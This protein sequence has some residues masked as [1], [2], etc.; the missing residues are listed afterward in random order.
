[1]QSGTAVRFFLLL[2]SFLVLSLNVYAEDTLTIISPTYFGEE[3]N[4]YEDIHYLKNEHLSV[5]LCTDGEIKDLSAKIVCNSN[6]TYMNLTTS[7]YKGANVCHFS[8]ANLNETPCADFTLDINYKTSNDKEKNIKRT[9]KRQA[10]SK[11]LNYI[12]GTNIGTLDEVE[13]SYFLIVSRD[14]GD[15][16]TKKSEEVYELLK[17]KRSNTDKCWPAGS[18]SQLKTS[19]IIRNLEWASYSEDTR[20]IEDGRIYLEKE[21]SDRTAFEIEGEIR[22]IHDASEGDINCTLT[23]NG[24]TT[25]TNYSID[26]AAETITMEF[27]DSF[28]FSCDG[29]M[30]K[31]TLTMFN[32]AGDL[33]HKTVYTS[34]SSIS[35]TNP[36]IY[37]LGDSQ[38]CDYETTLNTLTVYGSNIAYYD[39]LQD[40]LDT[41]IVIDTSENDEKSIGTSTPFEDSGKYLYYTSNT[42]LLQFLKFNQNNDGSWGDGSLYNNILD[43][44]WAVLG[45]QEIETDSEYVKD[46]KKWIYFN[47][48]TLGW[49]DMEKNVLAYRAIKEQIKPYLEIST[50]NDLEKITSFT[51]KNPTIYKLRDIQVSFSDTLNNHLSYTVDLG[52]L[53]TQEEVRFNVSVSPTF[54]GKESGEM[55]ISGVDGQNK[56]ITFI[57][58][59][60]NIGGSSP[61]QVI[62]G[63]YTVST[64]N[65]VVEVQIKGS[66]SFSAT[67]QAHNPFDGTTNNV[68]LSNTKTSFSLQNTPLIPGTFDE[69]LEC[70][71]NGET[72][73]LPY[74]MNIEVIDKKFEVSKPEIVMEEYEGFELKITSTS[75]V[76]E[77]ITVNITGSYEGILF[78]DL[79]DGT[80]TLGPGESETV[81]F[82][83]EDPTFLVMLEDQVQ[84]SVLMTSASDYTKEIQIVRTATMAVEEGESGG[85]FSWFFWIIVF[86][87]VLVVV[88][89]GL[90]VFRYY[91]L[92]KEEQNHE[93]NPN[94]EDSE[95]DIF[96]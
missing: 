60:I 69:N 16:F 24:D 41:Q 10:E 61:F 63:N 82:I 55:M 66:G 7:Q 85:G 13:L 34:S 77:I 22:V 49:R 32:F 52:D 15:I 51:V 20:L 78:P 70:D 72:I 35:Y 84:G 33:F 3:G 46:G 53:E 37:C 43:T 17:T 54:I 93:Q 19:K 44:S 4:V 62:S 31:A 96:L 74:T 58:M 5:K 64:D 47:E 42:D 27:T 87:I 29:N 50:V 83:M 39:S 56:R 95:E 79:A 81:D 8:N 86:F 21:I 89:G 1:M 59:P 71:I 40:F 94:H 76:E 23:T 68:S 14:L 18:C 75:D 91:E 38:K 36:D 2:L 6:K 12:L 25:G 26:S 45:M 9:F 65:P 73:N 30:E 48:P 57:T 67:C 88:I 80:I 90:T 11:L 92:K 28:S